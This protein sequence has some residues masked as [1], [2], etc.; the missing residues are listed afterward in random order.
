[1]REGGTKDGA[2]I[3]ARAAGRL[4]VLFT[5][6]GHTSLST[7]STGQLEVSSQRKSV[8]M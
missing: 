6:T 5:P 7:T 8:M 3:A 1:M 2:T 4:E